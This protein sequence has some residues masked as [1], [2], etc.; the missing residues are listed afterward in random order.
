MRVRTGALTQSMREVFSVDI[1]L[2]RDSSLYVL[3]TK[4]RKIG[5]L[6]RV[7]VEHLKAYK[8]AEDA[9]RLEALDELAR[10]AQQLGLGY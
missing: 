7:S 9:K 8:K 1:F 6:R 5:A 10:Q 3:R 4:R 2:G